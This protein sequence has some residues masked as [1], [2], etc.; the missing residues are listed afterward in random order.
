MSEC[1]QGCHCSSLSPCERLH[2][3]AA[4]ADS[5]SDLLFCKIKVKNP[6]CLFTEDKEIIVIKGNRGFI[7]LD[8]KCIFKVSECF[9]MEAFSRAFLSAT[10]LVGQPH[11]KLAFTLKEGQEGQCT[12]SVAAEPCCTEPTLWAHPDGSSVSSRS[13]PAGIGLGPS[14]PLTW[15][16]QGAA[17]GHQLAPVCERPLSLYGTVPPDYVTQGSTTLD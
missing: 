10:V 4:G 16:S 9:L 2:W 15:L 17:W 14:W 12:V 5:L 8:L 13:R 3:A 7:K 6:W 1:L 11:K